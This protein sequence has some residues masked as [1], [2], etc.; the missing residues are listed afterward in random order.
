MKDDFIF[1]TIPKRRQTMNFFVNIPKIKTTAVV[2][3]VTALTVFSFIFGSFSREVSNDK[4]LTY[5]YEYNSENKTDRTEKNE[6]SGKYDERREE[7][8]ETEVV[9][10]IEEEPDYIEIEAVLTAYCPCVECS[11]G[12]G[13]NTSTG[14]LAS[15][16]RTVAVDP[17]VIPY[18]T[19]IEIDGN[20]YIA[21]DCGGAVKGN[22]IDIYFDSHEKTEKFGKQKRTVKLYI[23]ASED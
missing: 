7:P 11:G 16:G 15:E 1:P 22:K 14:V 21:E 8:E 2:L 20:I 23:N 17:K 19:K 4:T 3:S 9:K 13:T 10:D 6:D 18:G 12:Y 5:S